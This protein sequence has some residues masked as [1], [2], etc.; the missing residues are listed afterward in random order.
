MHRESFG[1]R[2]AKDRPEP[3][4]GD[5]KKRRPSGGNISMWNRIADM[6]CKK[7]HTEAMWP[8]HGKYICPRCLREHALEW[9]GPATPAE[10]GRSIPPHAHVPMDSGVWLANHR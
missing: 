5:N 3:S 2:I 9:E 8:I 10:Y 6:W 4:T 7:M 1:M